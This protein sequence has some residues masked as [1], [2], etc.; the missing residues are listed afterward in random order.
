LP[1]ADNFFYYN[2]LGNIGVIAYSGAHDY[3]D[4]IPMFE[5]ACQW[6]T[7]VQ[8]EVILLLGMYVCVCIGIVCCRVLFCVLLLF[9]CIFTCI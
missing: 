5:E 4:S 7:E 2:K 9:T 3:T 8:P 6:A 1:S